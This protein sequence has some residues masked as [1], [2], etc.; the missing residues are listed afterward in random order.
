MPMHDLSHGPHRVFQRIENWLL[1]VGGALALLG[2]LALA[3]PWTASKVVD[4]LVGGS[5]IA[6]GIS[7]VGMAANTFS[8]RG[9]WLALVCG[10]LSI[11]A[12][13]AMLAIPVEGVHALVFFL[14]L[15]IL[16]EAA[17]KLTAAF[18]VPRDFPW[19]WLLLDGV[20]TAVL[21]GVLL[22]AKPEQAGVLLGVIVG[23]N[24]LSSGV[25]FLASGIW[26]RR[27]TG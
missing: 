19:G 20:V 5:L 7:Q 25:A 9:F 23:I 3:A 8:W 4:F 1:V 18:T 11:V 27:R 10:V 16:F 12:G 14:G 26:L 24:L 21:G 2:V 15:I 6:A 17:A 13:T 22:T